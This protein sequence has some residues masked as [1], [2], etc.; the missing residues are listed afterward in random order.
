MAATP[1]A[2]EL[3]SYGYI[4]PDIIENI[5]ARELSSELTLEEAEPVLQQCRELV[6]QNEE[7]VQ[8]QLQSI[9]ERLSTIS[10]EIS[11]EK[12]GFF[13]T[14]ENIESE[15]TEAEAGILLQSLENNK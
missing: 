8:K 14:A 2:D 5:R 13:H 3:A 1:I 12:K 9:T 15:G 11:D 6:L 4:R 10:R 7:L